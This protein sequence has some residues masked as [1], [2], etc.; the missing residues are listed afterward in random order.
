MESFGIRLFL[1]KRPIKTSTLCL[2]IFPL[3]PESTVSGAK[4]RETSTSTPGRQTILTRKAVHRLSP[5]HKFS[6]TSDRWTISSSENLGLGMGRSHGSE[7]VK[8][9]AKPIN[10]RV[11]F[12]KPMN[13]NQNPNHGSINPNSSR[14]SA[15]NL[16]TLG[17]K[18]IQR[19]VS[20]WLTIPQP[21]SR[22]VLCRALAPLD[23]SKQSF[24]GFNRDGLDSQC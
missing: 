9:V 19:F 4:V 7:S 24:L 8:R 21:G 18:R 12:F 14:K 1:L 16:W 22:M 6:R 11:V 17:S 5:G 15:Q 23:Q 3:L 13:P 2:C 20:A 10:S